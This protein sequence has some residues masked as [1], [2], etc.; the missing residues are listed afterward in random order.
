M[1]EVSDGCLAGLIAVA[2]P[3]KASALQAI[4]QLRQAPFRE[5]DFYQLTSIPGSG[6]D[7]NPGFPIFRMSL[8]KIEQFIKRRDR[9][10]LGGAH[11]Q[12]GGSDARLCGYFPRRQH[13]FHTAAAPLARFMNLISVRPSSHSS[14]VHIHPNLVGVDSG[15][16]A[17]AIYAAFL[18]LD[19]LWG[20]W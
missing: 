2:D 15:H 16:D 7:P 18:S 6:D 14:K 3:V 17:A 8:S 11:P 13:P 10:M 9:I 19:R 1:F 12:C 5:F 4:Q 20:T